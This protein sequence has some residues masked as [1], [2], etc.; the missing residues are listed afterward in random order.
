MPGGRILPTLAILA[1][2][3]AAAASACGDEEALTGAPVEPPVGQRT[4]CPELGGA[5]PA[6][7]ATPRG[8][9][10]PYG[11]NDGAA[12]NGALPASRAAALQERVG[13]ELWRVALDWRFAEPERGE[14]ELSAHD[15][16][17]CEALARGIRPIFHITG[18]PAW[19]ADDSGA[20]P[21]PSCIDPPQASALDD[22]RAFAELVAGRYPE[23]AAIEAWNEPNLAAFWTQPD[24]ARYASVLA[25]IDEGVDA[26][27]TGVPVLGGS[28]SNTGRTSTET[29]RYG[30]A[31]FL[32]GM[33]AAG[34]A[35]HM[36]AVAFHPYP[37]APLGSSEERLT[38]T[39]AELRRA[40]RRNG[41]AG[42][43]IW[44]TEVGL[45][46]GAGVSREEQARA[47][48]EIYDRLAADRDV[49]A[50]LFHTLL[51]GPGATG[52]G[53]GFGWLVDGPGGIA[54]RPVYREFAP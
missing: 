7:R 21:T 54:P 27:G 29:G 3:A 22:L 37:L 16:V 31:E 24:P 41:D 30:H 2:V 47:L 18:A 39:M 13:A 20:C 36:D 9:P 50:V 1:A 43:P 40:L 10:P 45:P 5:A 17:Y 15:A 8:G 26:A 25:A 11:F 23:L 48:R 52:A 34:A 12:L 14:L 42:R 6:T 49:E 33:Y 51:D 4:D 38:R 32:D 46:V 28:V 44:I 53:S 35:D 19:A